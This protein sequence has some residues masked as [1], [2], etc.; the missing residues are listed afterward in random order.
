MVLS[1][2][3]DSRQVVEAIRLGAEDY[4]NVPLQGMEL[5]QVLRR[6]LDPPISEDSGQ[7]TGS[8]H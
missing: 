2:S 6:Y 7:A 5:Q 1:P 8:G 4:L 3:A